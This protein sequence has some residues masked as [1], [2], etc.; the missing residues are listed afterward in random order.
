MSRVEEYSNRVA[1]LIESVG[2]EPPVIGELN[3]TAAR[4]IAD[5]LEKLVAVAR[6]ALKVEMVDDP[7]ID[8]LDAFAEL[9]NA[10]AAL[11]IDP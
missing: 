4:K 8:E 6:A 7:G 10:L 1:A 9:Q 11:E 5:A 2:L 3:E